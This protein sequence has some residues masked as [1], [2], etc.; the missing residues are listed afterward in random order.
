[1]GKKYTAYCDVVVPFSFDF[2]V[3]E[4]EDPYVYMYSSKDIIPSLN[5]VRS[6]ADWDNEGTVDVYQLEEITDEEYNNRLEDRQE[7]EQKG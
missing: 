1:M 5:D 3:P 7:R 6:L 4:G 2:E